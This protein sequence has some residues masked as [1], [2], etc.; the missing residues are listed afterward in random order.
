MLVVR[1]CASWQGASS[2]CD[3]VTLRRKLADAS[4]AVEVASRLAKHGKEQARHSAREGYRLWE[5]DA[6]RGANDKNTCSRQVH[7]L[8]F[9]HQSTKVEGS[10]CASSGYQVINSGNSVIKTLT[11]S[12]VARCQSPNAPEM[13]QIDWQI[14]TI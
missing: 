8:Q 13:K 5:A 9:M 14:P 11:D 4:V 7:L 6:S 12:T 2:R 10:N 3:W 1:I